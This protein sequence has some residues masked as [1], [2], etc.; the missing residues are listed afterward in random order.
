MQTDTT[1]HG[2][3]PMFLL[4]KATVKKQVW[5]PQ[6]T[7][8]NGQVVGGHYA[9][10]H[11]TDD[12]DHHKVASGQGSY[13]QKKAH[14]QLADEPEYHALPVEDK[15]ALVMHHATQIQDA[16]SQAARIATLRKKLLAG[17]KPTPGEWKAFHA[18]AP[19]KQQAITEAVHAAGHGAH[20]DALYADYVASV[21]PAPA[22]QTADPA[23]P[24]GKS[25]EPTATADLPPAPKPAPQAAGAGKPA[26]TVMVMGKPKAAAP[27][28]L[29]EAKAAFNA[30]H[31]GWGTPTF[32]DAHG[33]QYWVL[34]TGATNAKGQIN[35]H[36][37]SKELGQ[38]Q[39][40]GFS[41]KQL[42]DY[43][44]PAAIKSP[45][46]EAAAAA[47]LATGLAVPEFEEGKTT[48]GVKAHYEK[49][50]GKVIELAHA[51]DVAA[52]EALPD[53]EKG[54][55]W[56]GKTGNSKALLALHAQALAYAKGGVPPAAHSDKGEGDTVAESKPAAGPK[57]GD[58]KEGDTGTLV[59][60][61]GH[62][63]L[64]AEGSQAAA[65]LKQSLDTTTTVME[66]AKEWQEANPGHDSILAH[67][68]DEMG[69][70]GYADA[71]GL[72]Q[73]A[74]DTPTDGA[75]AAQ[76]AAAT[77]EPDDDKAMQALVAAFEAAKVP[78]ENT[79]A[80]VFNPKVDQI[81]AAAKA[82]DTDALLA[83]SYGTNT[84]GKKAAKLAN[85][86][87][88]F[89]GTRHQVAPGQKAGAHPKLKVVSIKQNPPAAPTPEAPA[90]AAPVDTPAPA[91]SAP[92]PPST[93]GM[94]PSKITLLEDAQHHFATGNLAK[95]ELIQASTEGL[96]GFAPIHAYVTEAIAH[97]GGAGASAAAAPGLAAGEIP[98]A[99]KWSDKDIIEEANKLATAGDVAALKQM[100]QH[101][102][103]H[104]KVANFNHINALVSKLTVKQKTAADAASPTAPAPAAGA[105]DALVEGWKAAIS[106]GKVPSK[107]QAEA[108]AAM[109]QQNEDE[110]YD[111]H[112]EVQAE[113]A[114]H[115]G[116]DLGDDFT[117]TLAHAKVD[118]LHHHALDG[119]EPAEQG[120]KNGDTKE[121]SDGMLVFQDG[122]WHKMGTDP[123]VLKQKAASVPV[124]KMKGTNSIKLGKTIKHLKAIAEMEG[125]EGLAKTVK[126]N[127][128]AGT[129]KVGGYPAISYEKEMSYGPAAYQFAQYVK[130]LH[131]TM[132]GTKGSAAPAAAPAAA[133]V[134]SIAANKT[135]KVGE[136]NAL[137]GDSWV[138][139]GPQ[140]GSNPGGKFKD[141][142][143]KEWYCKFPSDP[144]TVYN[145]LL[146]AKFYQMLGAKVPDLR[147]VQK[148]GKLGI[149]SAWVDGVQKGTAEQLAEAEGA[150]TG[151]IFDAWLAN[152]DVVGLANDNLMID[153]DGKAVRVDVGGSLIF[154]AQGGKKGDAFG[155]EVTELET[156][157]DMDK[158]SKS[159]AVFAGIDAKS[160]KIG[161]RQLAKVKPS[162]IEEMCMKAGPG[163]EAEKQ[164][165]AKLLIARRKFIL[166]KFA[167]LD[168][169]DKPPVD[170]T[171]V[172][173]NPADIPAPID[174]FHHP[175]KGGAP[176]SSK[177]WLNQQNSIDSAALSAFAKK[178][179]LKALKD[180]HY[181]AIDA[182][183]NLAG[184]KPITDHPSNHIQKQWASLVQT[185]Q[186]VAYPPAETLEMPSFG[187]GGT[188]EE[189]AKEAAAFGP[190]ENVTTVTA[191]H[192][193]GYFMKLAQAAGDVIHEYVQSKKWFFAKDGDEFDKAGKANY[194][195]NSTLVKQYIAG[196]Q[197]SGSINHV[198]SQGKTEAAGVPI[199]KLTK[200]IYDE[201]QEMPEGLQLY[202]WM[203][204]DTA[205]DIMTKQ[206][207]E[208]VAGTVLQNTDSMCTS[209]GEEWGATDNPHFCSEPKKAIL[210]RI[211]CA[212]GAK[213][214]PS[215]GTGGFS[216]EREITTLPG[217]RFVIVSVT[218]GDHRH[219]DGILVDCI[220][221]PPD[222]GFVAQLSGNQLNKSWIITWPNNAHPAQMKSR[223]IVFLRK[224]SRL[225]VP[226]L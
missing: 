161:A 99:S 133:P 180:Y 223:A 87:L 134:A 96:T 188:L 73:V 159:A 113:L 144:E 138:Q 31:E 86:A 52:L 128:D 10:V 154:R 53:P 166:K 169:W 179:D 181:Q 71:L 148:D 124:P 7:K 79:N 157:L 30:K 218:Q 160:L 70:A 64:Q 25:P 22:E 47:Q 115:L 44:D 17:G 130:Q 196:V 4:L 173:V 54:N 72:N 5:V 85:E 66:A 125:A 135:V 28:S 41:P 80:K 68:L 48:T 189:I 42:S 190:Q 198:W 117:P 163:T 193:F 137:V 60:K 18:A 211:R 143:G 226:T 65:Y 168:Q 195:K 121:G 40:N 205:G 167:V 132:A 191:E 206:L 158:N 2:H 187:V 75:H 174:F 183:G 21:L 37:A 123:K 145:E 9:H 6:F 116:M 209:Y 147:L 94:A 56:K 112:T 110:Y 219:P 216:S 156:L 3:R 50:A 26:R 222:E 140:G 151:F 1:L 12:H 100:A 67:T 172:Q 105:D 13:S 208:A 136:L 200:A 76:V 220:M 184:M 141:E 88:A 210:M 91:A 177:T 32:T 38:L 74:D 142:K 77:A 202:R 39:A 24:G 15:A 102:F 175:D 92:I 57:E 33:V 185:L 192:R 19:E 8:K 82:G 89:L 69:Y 104:D 109:K 84:Y 95:L 98:F 27:A 103:D 221:L 62:W 55:S 36:L 61:D 126:V 207:K 11:V 16:E 23:P 45:K 78:A 46:A 199:N 14:A 224:P 152:W 34:S 119:T 225:S 97:L 150:H 203:D 90:A 186:S 51:G 49:T 217:Q 93:E 170:E 35:A 197:A 213:A 131:D 127:L 139:T 120:P 59:L 58:T 111:H 146:A 178:G 182:S 107:P 204:D 149:A 83:M 101:E 214:T 171:S 194:Q 29:D 63:V 176:L 81:I 106:S 108:M 212:E 153:K 43:V 215:H 155:R 201:A 20:M 165:L 129:V 114:S 118:E 162:Q 164:A 122:R